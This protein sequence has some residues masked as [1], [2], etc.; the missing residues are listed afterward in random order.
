MAEGPVL[1][2]IYSEFQLW[3]YALAVVAMLGWYVVMMR[4]YRIAKNRSR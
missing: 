1:G 3:F 4:I 2:T